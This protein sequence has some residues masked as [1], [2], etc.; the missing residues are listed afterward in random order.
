MPETPTDRHVRAAIRALMGL[1][2]VGGP[3]LAR[4]L[5]LS[6]SGFYDRM[7]GRTRLSVGEVDAIA[8]RFEMTVPELIEFGRDLPDPPSDLVSASSRCTE[9]G[10]A[11]AD[12]LRAA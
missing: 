9:S 5:D 10:P 2:R 11:W 12:T 3:E 7:K 6:S 4:R 8:R 1:H